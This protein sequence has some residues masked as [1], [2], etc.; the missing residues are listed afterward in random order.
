MPTESDLYFLSYAREDQDFARRL[1][2]DLESCDYTLFFDESG[3]RSGSSWPKSIQSALNSCTCLIIVLSPHSVASEY[4]LNEVQYARDHGK[5]IIPILRQECDIPFWI[6]RIQYLDF[7]GA[8][9]H[10]F[11]KLVS[12]LRVEHPP[13]ILPVEPTS[14]AMTDSR[15]ATSRNIIVCFDH[16]LYPTFDLRGNAFL[17]TRMAESI[18]DRQLV[19]YDP[20]VEMLGG[21]NLWSQLRFDART[22][23]RVWRG[24]GI[25]E[26]VGSAYAF[27]MDSYRPGDRV[28]LFGSSAGGLMAKVLTDVLDTFGLLDKAG[29]VVVSYAV[30]GRNRVTKREAEDF[31]QA[32]SQDCHPYFFGLWDC[33][34]VHGPF[35]SNGGNPQ[36]SKHTPFGYNALAIDEQRRHFRPFVWAEP[37]REKQTI[38]QVWFAGAHA[39]VCGGYNETGLSDLALQW[40]VE[41]ANACGM[42]FDQKQYERLHPDPLAKMGDSWVGFWHLLGKKT[43]SIPGAASI[44]P[45]VQDRINALDYRPMNLPTRFPG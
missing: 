42:L 41:K 31:R 1:A 16:Q 38:E 30:Q 27:L 12:E 17:L 6:W 14:P 39:N 37:N 43:R 26:H 36:L 11:A 34:R 24:T 8:Y 28:F 4:V 19:Y 3:I 35:R 40:M 25:S 20:G 45:S 10:A 9:E 23:L 29:R 18:S 21:T 22:A 44:H 32:L 33:V 7:Q 2:K 13:Q 5:Q 15:Q